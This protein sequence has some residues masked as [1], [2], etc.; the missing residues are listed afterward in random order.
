MKACRSAVS[1]LTFIFMA[2]LVGC[3][4]GSPDKTA[5]ADR[6]RGDQDV[7]TVFAAASAT[8]ALD[9]VKAAFA[10]KFG[11]R[12]Q[13]SYAASSTLAEQIAS[14]AEPDIFLPAHVSWANY[15]GSKASVAR[16]RNLL[17][18]RL[19]VVV[20]SDSRLELA[21]PED[22]LSVDVEYLAL[23]DPDAVPA[24]KYAREALTA[25]GLWERIKS[26]VVPAKDVRDALTYV[27]TGAAEAAIVYATDASISKK[28]RVAIEIPPE[29]TE[30]VVYP[31]LLLNRS[32]ENEAAA[33]FY[34][35]I[36]SPEAAMI[37]KKFGFAVLPEGE[38]TAKRPG[39]KASHS[40]EP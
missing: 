12:V 23:G 38:D 6:R 35:Y 4:N 15:V 27:E 7:V 40:R 32:R 21:A 39:G 33:A 31:V 28:V 34:E 13:S 17:G 36:A 14:G 19:V 11:A 26:K 37:F 16:R 5:S 9:E 30:P 25:L 18:N 10:A 24:G 8:N 22:L 1:P 2:A 3:E 29:L 20:A